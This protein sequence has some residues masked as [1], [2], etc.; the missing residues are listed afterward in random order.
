MELHEYQS[1]QIFR[2]AGIPVPEGI[3]VSDLSQVNDA[4]GKLSFPIVVKAQVH[5]GG[6]GKAGGIKLGKTADEIKQ[7]ADA[8][9]GMTLRTKQT[10]EEGLLVKRIYLEEGSQIEAE[11]YLSILTDRETRCPII[12]ASKEG[13]MDIEEVAE[14]NPGALLK[15]PINVREGI[16][17]SLITQVHTFLSEGRFSKETMQSFLEGVY[18]AYLDNDAVMM[19]IN[20]V[21]IVAGKKLMALDAKVSLDDNAKFRHPEWSEFEI[22]GEQDPSEIEAAKFGLN[23]IKIGDGPIGCMVNG[24][25]LAMATMDVIHVF[26]SRP[27]NFLDVGGSAPVEAVTAAF[28]ILTNDKDVKAILVNIFGGIMKC[29]IIA[30]GILEALKIVKSDIPLVI[31]LEGTNVEKGKK[32]I[33]E[34]GL[35]CETAS[36]LSEA[37]KK[38]VALVNS[39]KL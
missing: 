23:Y 3:L 15:L 9:L 16:T 20:P 32:M 24:A 8:I 28:K 1:K 39:V 22:E 25:G 38:V 26:G 14:K 36:D 30:E 11:L 19:E 7:H 21:A 37:A 2:Q 5:A 35:Q 17:S 29:D 33:E 34:S 18:K 31:R 12:I 10:G 6:R 4:I 13:G 27:A